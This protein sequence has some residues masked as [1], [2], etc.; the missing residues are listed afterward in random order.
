[1]EKRHVLHPPTD[2]KNF[3]Q[4]NFI[5]EHS[6]TKFLT[7]YTYIQYGHLHDSLQDHFS[8][9]LVSARHLSPPGN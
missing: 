8:N 1:M 7:I 6:Q 5:E 2:S 3:K 9:L 4:E